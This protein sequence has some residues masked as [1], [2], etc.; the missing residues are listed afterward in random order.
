MGPGRSGSGPFGNQI[1]YAGPAGASRLIGKHMAE[2]VLWL[3]PVAALGLLVAIGQARWQWP[4]SPQH[5]AVLLWTGWLIAAGGVLSYMQGVVH[6]HYLVLLAPPV[7][8]LTGIAC[9]GLWNLYL[10][11]R[12]LCVLLPAGLGL[13]VAWELYILRNHVEFRSWL[14]SVLVGGAVTAATVL[15]V[16]RISSR[17]WRG[18][19]VVAG[20]AG[21][22]GFLTIMAGPATW[23]MTPV[24]AR[25]HWRLPMAY[26]GLL[27]G[28]GI[29]DQLLGPKPAET[30][31][32]VEF[33]RAN[34]QGERIALVTRNIYVA[35]ALIVESGEPV[36]AIGGFMGTDPTVTREQFAQLV[37]DKQVRYVMADSGRGGGFG[38]AGFGG[39]GFGGPAFGGPESGRGGPG[40]DRSGGR[41]RDRGLR[42]TRARGRGAG[43]RSGR[44]L[45]SWSA[46]G[47]IPTIGWAR[48]R[49]GRAPS[50]PA[51][52]AATTSLSGCG[53]TARSYRRSCGAMR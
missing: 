25:G 53:R 23:A 32:L 17:W 19:R 30:Q 15:V 34:R 37:A 49:V 40:S 52:S 51:S 20:V 22:V 3:I 33:L 2:Q 4:L 29:P 10:R 6:N 8:A 39:P 47:R 43:W 13:A 12:W 5:Q 16:T 44:K 18:W 48:G 50:V 42:W 35:S 38:P 41:S 1:G 14:P 7:A 11:N 24:L 36:I 27:R 31:K 26:P 45:G 28:E 46:G 9:G 21:A